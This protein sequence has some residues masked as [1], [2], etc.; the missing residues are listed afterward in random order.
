MKSSETCLQL[1]SDL[2][3]LPIF[4]QFFF[5]LYKNRKFA[6]QPVAINLFRKIASKIAMS[7]KL[8]TNS[9]HYFR[10]LRCWPIDIIETKKV[11]TNNFYSVTI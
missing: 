9:G 5:V 11:A 3:H 6:K 8:S 7:S 2:T 1:H 4:D 10:T